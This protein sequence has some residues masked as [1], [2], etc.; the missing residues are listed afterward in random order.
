MST[1]VLLARPSTANYDAPAGPL[2]IE[3]GP[4]L[5]TARLGLDA[6]PAW[7]AD[8]SLAL[9]SRAGAPD[10]AHV[11]YR[12]GHSALVR[13]AILANPDGDVTLQVLLEGP[14]CESDRLR[15]VVG[16]DAI[17]AMVAAATEARS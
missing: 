12:D 5:A 14:G 8:A 4:D 15:R 9:V 11:Q 6:D 17:L 16:I 13:L 1:P 7:P 10:R 3:V 2:H